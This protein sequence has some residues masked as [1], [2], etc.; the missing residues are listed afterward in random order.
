MFEVVVENPRDMTHSAE[1]IVFIPRRIMSL[2][3]HQIR[4]IHF[5]VEAPVEIRKKRPYDKSCKQGCCKEEKKH[6]QIADVI[7]SVHTC[8][9]FS[10]CRDTVFKWKERMQASEESGYHLDRIG[11]RRTGKLKDN[12]QHTQSLSD[13]FECYRQSINDIHVNEGVPQTGNDIQG[14]MFDMDPQKQHDTRT[15][16]KSLNQ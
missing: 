12:E 7:A 16:D 2:I 11:S 6:S 8:N 15:D 5:P 9:R 10:H 1:D 4:V 3:G 14:R 13:I